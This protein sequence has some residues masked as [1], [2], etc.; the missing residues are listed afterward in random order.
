MAPSK[1]ET[2]VGLPK[3]KSGNV[4]STPDPLQINRRLYNQVS[5]L[6]KQLEESK[7][8]TLKERYMALA[9]IA[10]IQYIF[11]NLR[12]EKI[13]DPDVGSTVRKYAGAFAK[14]DTRRRT[15]IAGSALEPEPEPD[16]FDND[17]N[18]DD[19]NDGNAA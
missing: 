19:D 9:S 10:R 18:G 14:N 1:K 13:G 2:V 11:V 15:T 12:K 4:V 6:L 5:E 7:N 16:W 17:D 3:N 8:V